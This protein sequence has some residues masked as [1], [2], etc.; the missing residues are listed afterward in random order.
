MGINGEA[1]R[2]PPISFSARPSICHDHIAMH[3]FRDLSTD[4]ILLESQK[5]KLRYVRA[6][7][8]PAIPRE[9]PVGP[10]PRITRSRRGLQKPKLGQTL[11]EYNTP[12]LKTPRDFPRRRS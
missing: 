6:S 10:A 3:K 7:R 9:A 1:R 4:F 2:R 11:S 12:I 5:G 8:H